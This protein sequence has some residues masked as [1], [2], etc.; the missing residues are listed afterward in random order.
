MRA[1]GQEAVLAFLERWPHAPGPRLRDVA[2]GVGVSYQRVQQILATLRARGRV[3]W[4]RGGQ[5]RGAS[6][7]IRLAGGA[8]AAP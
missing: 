4:T 3:T 8:H 1:S 2:K 5:G 7:D 6:L